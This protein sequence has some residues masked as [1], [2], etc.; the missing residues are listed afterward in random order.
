N[1]TGQSLTVD[2]AGTY[3]VTITN[4]YNCSIEDSAVVVVN[5]LPVV[6][7][8]NDTMV[9]E[10]TALTF[11]AANPGATY[12][13]ST[14]DTTQQIT[15][16]QGGTYSVTVTNEYNCSASDDV[17]VIEYPPV[18]IDGFTFVPKFEIQVGRVDFF[19]LNPQLVN[20][21]LWDFGD[22]NTS[23]QATPIH[24]YAASGNYLVSLTVSNECSVRDTSLLIYV[25]LLTGVKFVDADEVNVNIYPVPT[26]HSLN[27]EL[28]ETNNNIR[29][30]RVVN[31]I[32]QTLIEQGGSNTQ[33][34]S[35]DVSNLSAGNYFIY[36]ETDHGNTVRKFNKQD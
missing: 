35:V 31:T 19:P 9:C 33:K 15:V 27:V 5:P 1:S 11:D 32:G 29:K 25:D 21:Y 4:N 12:L 28:A 24:I 26:Q 10:N 18:S 3:T 13:W 16:N 8:G 22:G 34:Q 23:T 14:G 36:I 30:I 17:E 2:Q 7:L 20:E 6:E